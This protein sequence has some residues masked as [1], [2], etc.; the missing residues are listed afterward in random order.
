MGRCED[1]QGKKYSFFQNK[2][3][4]YF[5]CHNAKTDKDFNCLFCFCPLYGMDDCGGTFSYLDNGAKNCCGCLLPHRQ[6]N[7]GYIIERL[8]NAEA[9]KD[10]K[11]AV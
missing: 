2:R 6:D 4:E 1:W 9:A 8:I 5:P 3:C 10:K 7:Y 11:T